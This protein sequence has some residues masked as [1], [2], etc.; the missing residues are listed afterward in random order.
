MAYAVEDI[1]S[2]AKIGRATRLRSR[3]WPSSDVAIGLPMSSRLASDT[4]RQRT[5]GPIAART[6]PSRG[7]G[8]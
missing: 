7:R 8:A 4:I 3:W 1:A 2:E 5:L 6:L